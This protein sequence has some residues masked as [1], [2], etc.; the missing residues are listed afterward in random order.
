M[1][2]TQSGDI[3]LGII[4]LLVVLKVMRLEDITM[5]VRRTQ[6]KIGAMSDLWARSCSNTREESKGN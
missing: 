3:N 4:G 2:E 1:G 6:K 5:K